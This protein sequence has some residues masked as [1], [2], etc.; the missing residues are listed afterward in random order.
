GR[1]ES[2]PLMAAQALFAPVILDELGRA[3]ALADQ[4]LALSRSRGSVIGL[5]I[6]A[7]VRAAV[8][9]RRGELVGAETELRAVIE[10]A[11]EHG[12]AFAVPSALYFG[13]DA[14]IEPPALPHLPRPPCTV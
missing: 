3:E 10:I 4:L 9:T 5:V 2:E 6:A 14:L 12:M 8:H 13:A 7:C 11:M 1:V